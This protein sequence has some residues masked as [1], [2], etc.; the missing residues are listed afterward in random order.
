MFVNTSQRILAPEIMDDLQMEGEALRSTLDQIAQ[1]NQLLGGNSITLEGVSMLMEDVPPGKEV[2]I[3]DIGCGNG[4]MLRTVARMAVKR[5]WRLKLIGIDANQYTIN[6]AAT[7]SAQYPEITYYCMDILGEKFREMQYDI[8]L[9][10]LTLHHFEDRQITK[11][12][13]LFRRNATIG[14]VINDLHRSALSYRL[15]QLFSRLAGMGKMA[16][17]DG[18]VSILRGFKRKE[19]EELSRKLNFKQYTLRWKWAFRYQWIITN[20]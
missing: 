19:I 4:D 7:L 10:T 16:K 3:A 18:L 2:T 17:E 8:V 5:G 9:C 12:M 20:V 15:F 1:I 14:I 6:Y 11:L 13:S